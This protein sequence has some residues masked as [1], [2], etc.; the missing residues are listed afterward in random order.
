MKRICGLLLLLVLLAVSAV[1]VWA[2]ED[3]A[4]E[5]DA[6]ATADVLAELVEALRTAEN[7]IEALGAVR[8]A[9]SL[10]TAACSG[11]SFNSDDEGLMPVIGPIEIPEGV[12]RVTL[13]TEG[14]F[15]M[16]VD[17]LDGACGEGT[18]MSSNAFNVGRDSATNGAEVVIISEGCEALLS[19][20]N[21]TKSWT[22]GFEKLR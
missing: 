11:L 12:Y 22:L 21:V 16:K 2:Q 14:Y 20:S 10:A 9:A 5:C 19:V 3:E 1:S 13:V 6:A 4:P 17:A 18:R 15:I 8:D 7:P